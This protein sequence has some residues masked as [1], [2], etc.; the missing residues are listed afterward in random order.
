MRLIEG[1]VV[2]RIE[3]FKFAGVR[4]DRLLADR[5]P[6]EFDGTGGGGGIGKLA[7]NVGDENGSTCGEVGR[8]EEEGGRLQGS[9]QVLGKGV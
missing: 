3:D 2:D 5:F 8:L 7:F 1:V 9:G 6:L 4:E